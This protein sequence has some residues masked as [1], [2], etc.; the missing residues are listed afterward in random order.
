MKPKITDRYYNPMEILKQRHSFRKESQG[1]S[2]EGFLKDGAVSNPDH[3][4]R[5]S[6][7]RQNSLQNRYSVPVGN[8][9]DILGN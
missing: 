7:I 1:Q 3:I 2:N 6:V 9:F 4:P 5:P 8:N